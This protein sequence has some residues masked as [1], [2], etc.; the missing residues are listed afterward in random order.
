MKVSLHSDF[1]T[2]IAYRSAHVKRLM[3]NIWENAMNLPAVCQLKKAD[4]LMRKTTRIRYCDIRQN[5]IVID[6]RA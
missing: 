3:P 2:N 5:Q 1:L 4:H 6:E